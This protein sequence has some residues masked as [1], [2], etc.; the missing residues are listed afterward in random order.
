MRVVCRWLFVVCHVDVF[1]CWLLMFVHNLLG[2]CAVC[3]LLFAALPC[4]CCLLLDER[5]LLCVVSCL[6][7]VVCNVLFVGGPLWFDLL[8]VCWSLFDVL[9]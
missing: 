8:C 4:V 2:V 1:V 6:L 5:C 3:C 7:S 9:C